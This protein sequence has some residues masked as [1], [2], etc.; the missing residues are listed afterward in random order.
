MWMLGAVV[1]AVV[2]YM[3]RSDAWIFGVIVGAVLGGVVSRKRERPDDGR[4][5]E[6]ERRLDRLDA[7]LAAVEER[8][9]GTVDQPEPTSSMSR[10]PEIAPPP[11]LAPEPIE[12]L[13]ARAEAWTPPS[14]ETS[15]PPPARP[16]QEP[17]SKGLADLAVW[18]WLA[19]GNTVV[20]VGVVI[21][22]FGVAFLLKYAHE[23]WPAGRS[24]GVSTGSWP[25][26][27]CGRSS[28]G[29]WCRARC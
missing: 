5:A 29:R 28:A 4:S 16:P 22:F 13:A 1:G 25:G 9:Q 6:L 3:I 18:R 24:A 21:L 26:A 20:R 23:H 27:P 12:P 11:P 14:V 8:L 17:P 7:R 19:G 2:G 15:E 10:E